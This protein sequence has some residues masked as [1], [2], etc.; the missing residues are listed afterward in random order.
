MDSDKN[1]ISLDFRSYND[2][3]DT[4]ISV[5]IN[6]DNVDDQK[7]KRHLNTWLLAIGSE[8]TVS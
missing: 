6:G 4:D 8:L 2:N 5:S 1:N 7:L 3:H